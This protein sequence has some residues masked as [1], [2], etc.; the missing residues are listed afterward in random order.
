MLLAAG[1]L[2]FP[3]QNL[4]NHDLGAI[5]VE[6]QAESAQQLSG[7]EPCALTN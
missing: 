3:P 5:G 4:V 7:C 2:R 1:D 6:P